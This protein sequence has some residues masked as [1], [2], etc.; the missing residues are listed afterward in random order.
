MDKDLEKKRIL[1]IEEATIKIKSIIVN[2]PL[3]K[4]NKT[5]LKERCDVIVKDTEKKLKDLELDDELVKTSVKA[6]RM[7]F[8]WWYQQMIV[9]LEKTA[10]IDTTGI[11]KDALKSIKNIDYKSSLG[12]FTITANGKDM[13]MDQVQVTNLRELMTIYD[14]GAA[15]RYVDYVGQIKDSLVDI[16]NE[17]ANGT[18]SAIDSLGR[19]K[20]IRNMA[21]I[22][23][24]YDLINEDLTK[25]KEKGTRFVIATAHA[26]ASER[27]SWWQGKIFVI[28]IDI[29]TRE[30]GQYKG[31]PTPT[32]KG[33]IDG[34]PYYSLKEACEN[35]FLS[36]NCQHRVI[37]YYKGVKVPKYNL[38]E[39]KKR[40]DI[41]SKQRYL[42]NK[43][44]K[45]KTRQA[46]AV[47]P[48]ERK[49]AIEESKRLQQQY[50]QFC[51]DNNVPRYDWRT[52]VTEVERDVSPVFEENF[53]KEIK[54]FND[55]KNKYLK[56]VE[57]E[58]KIEPIRNKNW[59]IEDA[60]DEWAK[61][62]TQDEQNAILDY[63]SG[64]GMDL[65]DYHRRKNYFENISEVPKG[66]INELDE[67]T[68]L[69]DS[70]IDKFA[71]EKD[72]KVYRRVNAN[73]LEELTGLKANDEWYELQFEE[74]GLE[75]LKRKLV[76]K[77][78]IDNG[79]ISTA[80]N[81]DE[82]F[83]L[84]EDTE[85]LLEIDVPKGSKGAFIGKYSAIEDQTELMLARGSR[86]DI[87]DIIIEKIKWLDDYGEE[88]ISK[89]FKIKM[90][91]K[92]KAK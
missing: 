40:R 92:T 64:D 72:Q 44:R 23:T 29:A 68:K 56:T 32:K 22:K 67:K 31:K 53:T 12:G 58:K 48:K 73:A 65:N 28:D 42:E 27:C 14:E 37:A 13:A 4:V 20:S 71:L 43:I 91:D 30:M 9:M 3:D 60:S 66:Y 33:T 46:L 38:V 49:E 7:N 76:G 51:K 85:I 74:N 75:K 21:E 17:I 18:L 26:N 55:N 59:N 82:V 54:E 57:E 90:K 39:V 70:A 89:V 50:N 10:K 45:A 2:A 25:L 84:Y 86:F 47:S 19:K 78:Y 77:E 62:L 81:R 24:R 80:L 63:T 69:L 15:G 35:G 36:F 87:E 11:V 34:K 8:H 52:R 79:Y 16:Q 41:T 1:A 88:Q 83:R 5:L 61:N 6:L